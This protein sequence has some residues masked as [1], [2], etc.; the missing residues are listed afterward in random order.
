MDAETA[1]LLPGRAKHKNQS[2]R[3]RI[4]TA[5]A[6]LAIISGLGFQF[7][8]SDLEFR[9][10]DLLEVDGGVSIEEREHMEKVYGHLVGNGST[11]IVEC[12]NSTYAYCGQASCETSKT[13]GE[14]AV[15]G[16]MMYEGVVGQFSM[17]ASSIMLIRSLIYREAVLLAVDG[18]THAAEQKVCN[19][20]RD[21]S[22]WGDA[23]YK[24][25]KFGSF[26]HSTKDSTE[27][28]Y[29]NKFLP[30]T[31]GQHGSCMGSPCLSLDWERGTGTKKCS[32]TCVCP[33]YRTVGDDDTDDDGCFLNG[34]LNNS[35]SLLWT[36]S[37]N[38]L[39]EYTTQLA[40]TLDVVN[41]QALDAAGECVSCTIK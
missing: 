24:A 29:S 23:G 38:A 17:D 39:L 6:T 33:D 22:I 20:L 10:S 19:A 40:S 16:C 8:R 32:V 37:L 31:S 1:S 36:K 3:K 27:T 35:K 4:V 13:L 7:R 12:P 9:H 30:R 5:S 15:C 21:G 34:V 25:A 28:A 14:T 2:W 26:Y 18:Y 11:Y 41:Y